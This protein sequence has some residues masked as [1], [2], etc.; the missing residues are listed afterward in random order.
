MSAA[1]YINK[2]RVQAIAKNTK[3][4]Y[5]GNVANPDNRLYSATNCPL[6]FTKLVYFKPNCNPNSN[7]PGSITICT[8]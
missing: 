8:G 7:I 4:N 5:Q 2:I 1:A 3:V 6:N